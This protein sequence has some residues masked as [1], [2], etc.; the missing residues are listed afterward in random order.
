M[1]TDAKEAVKPPSYGAGAPDKDAFTGRNGVPLY[2]RNGN[3]NDYRTY[4]VYQRE[5]V[6]E[7][8][9]KIRPIQLISPE[10]VKDP[11]PV[12]EILR[13][14]YPFYRDWLGNSFWV[15]RY[16]DVTSIFTDDANFETRPKRWFYG[17]EDLGRDLSQ[18]VPLLTAQANRIDAHLERLTHE[19]ID[20]FRANGGTDIAIEFAARL[21][22]EL[23]ACVLDLPKDDFPKF[24]DRY[25]RMQRGAM[26]EPKSRQSGLGAIQ[27]LVEYFRPL[28]AARRANP[29]DDYVSAVAT[30]DPDGGP[31]SAE[32]LVVTL[33]EQDH[34]TL[35]GGLANMWFLLLTHSGELEKVKDERRMMKFAWLETL[36]HS[37]PVVTANRFARHEV[38]RFGRLIPIGALLHCSAAAANRDPRQYRDPDHFLVGR[39][40]LCQR[41]PRGQYRADGLPAGVTFGLGKPSK[42]PAVPEDRPRSLYALTR[43]TATTASNML[44]DALPGLRLKPGAAPEL[45]SLRLGEMHTCWSLPVVF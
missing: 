2:T 6:K 10:F 21:P 45:R 17:I 22:L 31:A 1:S 37:T 27:E 9:D 7:A 4:E 34:E 24:V 25:W 8:T 12:L 36:R 39:K 30:L 29:G 11:Y 20:G 19:I 42:H 23:L 41:E 38:E 33:L 44:L 26:W 15:T 43:D 5:R 32:D 35:H 28:L 13:E 14:N 16:D 40:D 3:Q 18:E